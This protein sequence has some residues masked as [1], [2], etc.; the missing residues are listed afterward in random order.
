MS[1]GEDEMN[2]DD[3]L[4]L[5]LNGDL[6]EQDAIRYLGSV[7]DD[8]ELVR[9]I[10]EKVASASVIGGNVH[11]AW[12]LVDWLKSK[13]GGNSALMA[14]VIALMLSSGTLSAHVVQKGDTL[15]RL[16]GGTRKGMENVLAL[17]PCLTEGTV[18]KPG[19]KIVLPNE[20][21]GDAGTYKVQRGDTMSGIARRLGVSLKD[22][23]SWNPQ[24]KDVD[25]LSVGQVL[26]TSKPSTGNGGMAEKPVQ[27]KTD[28]KTDFVARVIYAESGNSVDEMEM[29]A[30]LIVNRM[31]SGMFPSGAYD[32]VR[33]RGQFSCATGT[34]GN[35]KWRNWSRGLNAM[36]RKAYELAEKVVNGDASGMKGNDSS[37]F[38]CTKSLARNGVGKGTEGLAKDY[39]HPKGWGSYST[40]TPVETSANHVF[41]ECERL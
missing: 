12:N 19:M 20:S 4:Q 26:N 27:P 10:V 6:S 22:L 11:V 15:W 38:Y 41:Y 34:D 24:V 2:G 32:V 30:H 17:N 39:G 33:Q 23:V 3:V 21:R 1:N 25:M 36:T 7:C 14:G 13:C 40:F 18:L 28:A 16:G 29:I 31:K 37:L 9:E 8:D 5:A 35:A